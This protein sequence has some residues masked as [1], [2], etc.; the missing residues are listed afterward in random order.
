M[1]RGSA[2]LKYRMASISIARRYGALRPWV[3]GGRIARGYRLDSQSIFSKLRRPLFTARVDASRADAGLAS[4]MEATSTRP[5]CL[6]LSGGARRGKHPPK[7]HRLRSRT[8]RRACLGSPAR[9]CGPTTLSRL[10]VVAQ[11]Q[12]RSWPR[13]I[14]SSAGWSE[15]YRFVSSRGA[16]SSANRQVFRFLSVMATTFQRFLRSQGNAASIEY[17]ADIAELEMV[18]RAARYAADC[19][20]LAAEALSSLRA[21]THGSTDCASCCIRRFTWCSRVSRS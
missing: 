12:S 21:Q 18:T 2:E 3:R 13:G 14:P 4:P 8:R 1:E 6:T 15:S 17:V 10:I 5:R 11:S 20:A 7:C 19:P 16:S 9:T